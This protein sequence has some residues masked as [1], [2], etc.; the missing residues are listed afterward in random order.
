MGTDQEELGA[1]A[2][3]TRALVRFPLYG[4]V[5]TIVCAVDRRSAPAST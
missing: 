4:G 1:A 2:R 5:A 3:A